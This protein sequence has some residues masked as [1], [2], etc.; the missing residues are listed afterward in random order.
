M[1]RR[2]F[3]SFAA[4][5]CA[6]LAFAHLLRTAAVRGEISDPQ[7]AVVVG[8]SVVARNKATGVERTATTNSAGLFTLSGLAPGEYDVRVTAGGF[9]PTVAQ[10]RLEVG[11]EQNLK[12]RLQLRQ[13]QTTITIDDTQAAP[14][15]NTTSSLVDGV[16]SSQQID[17]LP[18][19]GRNFLELALLMPGN[20]PA[21][22][23]DPTKSDTV[24]ISTGGQL[25]RGANVSID[26]ADN[27]DDVA[28]G[29][30]HHVPE[31]AVQE[32]QIASNQYSAALGR[33]GSSVV[34]VVTKSGTNSLRGTAG[35]RARSEFAGEVSTGRSD[36]AYRYRRVDDWVKRADGHHVARPKHA[37]S[38]TR[39]KCRLPTYS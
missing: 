22:N 33:S 7:G 23:F 32:F 30:L 9:G 39:K 17:S 18:L 19:N 25:G 4:L 5:L 6:V 28:G 29:M 3:L 1:T 38:S 20:T 34:N 10:V 13:E 26:G 12:V 14:L 21:P 37:H 11:Q 35:L 16:V 27:N 8:A 36:G 31:D 2:F 15:V 24:L